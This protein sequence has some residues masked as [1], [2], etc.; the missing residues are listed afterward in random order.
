M[1]MKKGIEKTGTT[2]IA[3]HGHLITSQLHILKGL[4]QRTGDVFMGTPRTKY[5]WSIFIQQ[6]GHRLP[7]S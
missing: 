7:P 6:T 2:D 4:I 5:R 1:G 3:D